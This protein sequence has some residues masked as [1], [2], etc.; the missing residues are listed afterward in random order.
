LDLEDR[1]N[2]LNK[3]PNASSAYFTSVLVDTAQD[4]HIDALVSNLASGMTGALRY[5]VDGLARRRA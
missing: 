1:A 3:V 4:R 5:A 2:H